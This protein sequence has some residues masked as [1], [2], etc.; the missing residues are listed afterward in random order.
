MTH[1]LRGFG[2]SFCLH[3]MA[4]LVVLWFTLSIPQKEK[5]L[6]VVDFSNISLAG[7]QEG[8]ALPGHDAATPEA[9]STAP[10]S[11]SF[12]GHL[13]P[14]QHIPRIIEPER[15]KPVVQET[16]PKRES[17]QKP[18]NP[19]P[20]KKQPEKQRK[21]MPVVNAQGTAVSTSP[22]G[23]GTSGTTGRGQS[24][25]RGIGPGSGTGQEQGLAQGYAKANFNYILVSIR[26]NLEY[27]SFAKRKR[28]TGI[29][30][31]SFVIKMDGTIES[32]RM[33]KSSGHGILDEAAEKAI[34]KAAPFPKPPTP[35][36]LVVPID[37]RLN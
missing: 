20:E 22:V 10:E 7:M 14:E 1:Y 11:A 27:P 3:G 23:Q 29:A 4:V 31:F 26:R 33:E 36:L 13:E 24:D 37:F 35:A 6:L 34:R 21:A 25:G 17:P 32:L 12:P 16:V 18:K 8:G 2:V 19:A 5:A 28:L 9:A 30:Q 15:H